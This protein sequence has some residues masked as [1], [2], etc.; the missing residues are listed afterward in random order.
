MWKGNER[1]VAAKVLKNLQSEKYKHQNY[2]FLQPF[3]LT[4]VPGYLDLI[5][6]PLDLQTVSNQLQSGYYDNAPEGAS[7]TFWKDVTAV[8]GNAIRYHA[9]KPTKWIAKMAKDMIKVM[10]K[11]RKNAEKPKKTS[12]NKSSS[13][14]KLKL[15]VRP[16]SA[17]SPAVSSSNNASRTEAQKAGTTATEGTSLAGSE[18]TPSDSGADLP[19]TKKQKSFKIKLSVGDKAGTAQQP[20]PTAVKAKPTQP[21]LRLTLKKPKAT[22]APTSEPSKPTKSS[23][24]TTPPT[25][26]SSATT[27][28]SPKPSRGKELPQAV[29]AS[30]QKQQTSAAK[31]TS[32]TQSTAKATKKK[33]K[34]TKA[35]PTAT[36][37]TAINSSKTSNKANT[38]SSSSGM[39]APQRQQCVEVLAG[40]RRRQ[41]KNIGWFASP[42]SDKSIL[43]D[44]R[45]KIKHPIDLATV[46][47]KLEKGTYNKNGLKDFCA[48]VRRIFSNALRY[49]TSIKDSL[50]PVA[51][52]VLE[53]AELLFKAFFVESSSSDLPYPPLIFC[54]KLCI[55]ILDT[56]YNLVNPT[57]GQPTVLYFLHP[58]SYY[59]GGKFPPDY[60]ESIKKPMDFG[61]VTANLLG[62]RYQTVDAF[63]NDC[64]LVLAN[65][66]TYYGN[67]VDGAIYMEQAN[68]LNEYLTRQLDQ[69]A[70]YVK[71]SKGASDRLRSVQPVVLPRPPPALLT[72]IVAELRALKF[73]DKAT[74]I[75]EPAMG[76]FEKPVSLAVFPDYS[77]YVPEPM[78]LQAVERKATANLYATPEDF[79]Y[80]INLIFRNCEVYNARRGGDHLVA[81]AKYGARQFRRLFYAR[82]REF[83]DPSSVPP[84][85]VEPVASSSRNESGPPAAKKIKISAAGVSRG[86]SAPRISITASMMAPL[87]ATSKSGTSKSPK[88]TSSQK[89]EVSKSDQPVPL[90]IAIAR[91]KEAFP[92]RRAA[93]SLQSWEADSARYFKELMR[94]PWISGKK[95]IFHVPVP[96]LFPS[97]KDVYASKIR[98]PMDLTTVEC[99]LLAGNRYASP[100]DLV[101]D[102]ALV[103]SNAIRFNKAGREVGDP[104]SC[105]YYAA[106]VHLLKYSRWLSLELLSDYSDEKTDYK[107]EEGPDGLPPFHWKLTA[108]NRKRARAEMDALVL[109]EPLDKSLE[110]DRYTWHEAECEKLLKAL[111]H[112]SDLRHMTF[113]ITANYPADYTAFIVK[114]MD[115]ETVQRNLKARR[116]DSFGAVISDL[117]LIFSN[118]EKYNARL[119]G[120]DTVSGRAYESARYM[121]QKLESAINKMVLTVADRIERERIDHANAEREIEARER[122][123]EEKIRAAWKKERGKDG[124]SPTPPSQSDIAQKIRLVRRAAQRRDATDFEMPFFDE[125]DNGQHE[126]S[127][128]EA[129]KVQ[130]SIYEK[131]T[132]A[133]VKMRD[134]TNRVGAITFARVWHRDM[135]RQWVASEAK[136]EGKSTQVRSVVD[137]MSATEQ[138]T[139]GYVAE[140]G[141]AA[142]SELEK[143]GRQRLQLKLVPPA[144]RSTKRKRPR[145][146]FE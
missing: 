56:L 136:N 80:D 124:A 75:T 138:R 19:T 77:Q 47:S 12:G 132:Q 115:W 17:S 31:P 65:C 130:K 73:A 140:R 1:E 5:A 116:Y 16:M 34:K 33:P 59:C 125:E 107:D 109:K 84:P 35:A 82:M 54:W 122:A 29:A 76:P 63:A 100:E 111:R 135:A 41:A 108:G 55:E 38:S 74:K 93:K 69:L 142:L 113:F 92:L 128:F 39:S 52:Q 53:T 25:S 95:F 88:T 133:L 46:Q 87:E 94:H 114:P 119:K 42:V 57:D 104:I 139:E 121:S 4:Q 10:N 85:K 126:Q 18:P 91:V 146:N 27:K 123:E 96:T 24:K 51:V 79:E 110:G 43:Q 86:K 120:T 50:R 97:L 21:K 78:D 106:S 67:R 60:T 48:D 9:D 83:E 101:Q 23:P 61:T 99:T 112:Q 102:V 64:R 36:T 89:T 98:K 37:K 127:Y 14:K 71:S 137:Q 118:A 11:E 28:I 3:D 134:A 20:K 32:T 117:R 7:E 70:R 68:R 144:A 141:S 90:H 44:Y 81:M 49:N 6:K 15:L 143:E 129:I 72:S 13:K 58:V 30:Q 62:A 103:F 40:L 2:L 66:R 45:A 145:L 8:F 26:K 131:Q 22:T 105:A